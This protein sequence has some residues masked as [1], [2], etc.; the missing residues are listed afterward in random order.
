MYMLRTCGLWAGVLSRS[1]CLCCCSWTRLCWSCT[2]WAMAF[3]F[4]GYSWASRARICQTGQQT[5][6]SNYRIISCQLVSKCAACSPLT[7]TWSSRIILTERSF[8]S[9]CRNSI[10]SLLRSSVFSSS[11][12]SGE[13]IPSS[14]S[15]ARLLL[16]DEPLNS[17][18]QQNKLAY[19]CQRR[20]RKPVITGLKGL[21]VWFFWADC[22]AAIAASS[23]APKWRC[24][25]PSAAGWRPG[26][27]EGKNWCC[28][29]WFSD[30]HAVTSLISDLCLHHTLLSFS[31]SLCGMS[32]LSD[33]N[34][35]LMLCIRRRS[36][37]LAISL[38]IRL[39]WSRAVSGV[40]GMLARLDGGRD[41]RDISALFSRWNDLK[42]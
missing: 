28:E 22:S 10:I 35:A 5:E 23:P 8:S 24:T 18:G 29:D 30:L 14:F 3:S 31:P 38:R 4:S 16:G 17:Y 13:P 34:P 41:I 1:S 37:L 32:V 26:D 42:L 27:T 36:L 39:S 7:L 20:I 40:K 15:S 6:V 33:W 11:R 21:L 2:C 25:P 9:C 12:M 19:R